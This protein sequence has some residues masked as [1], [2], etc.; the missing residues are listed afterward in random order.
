VPAGTGGSFVRGAKE[1]RSVSVAD[2]GSNVGSIRDL[3]QIIATKGLKKIARIG[4][5]RA[6]KKVEEDSHQQMSSK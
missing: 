6:K 4:M 2:Y 3:I 5:P 1:G